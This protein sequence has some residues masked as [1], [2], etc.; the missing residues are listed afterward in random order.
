MKKT[1]TTKHVRQALAL[2]QEGMS[3]REVSEVVGFSRPSIAAQLRKYVRIRTG[4]EQKSGPRDMPEATQLEAVRLYE[5]GL[6]TTDIAERLGR[7]PSCFVRLLRRRG[8]R[9]RTRKQAREAY[10]E[11][12]S[13]ALNVLLAELH[14]GQRLSMSEVAEAVGKNLSA[15]QKRLQRMGVTRSR[16]EAVA[17]A[18]DIRRETAAQREARAHRVRALVSNFRKEYGAIP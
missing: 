5:H 7:N 13:Q 11:P 9:I 18:A 1:M 6:S 14:V 3:L 17:N 4:G 2:Y 15:V 10:A 12:A 16:A 8:V